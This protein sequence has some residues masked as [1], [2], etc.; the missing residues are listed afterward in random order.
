MPT[1]A[2]R[3]TQPLLGVRA[4]S[5]YLVAVTEVDVDEVL[6]RQDGASCTV[7]G[8]NEKAPLANPVPLGVEPG[9]GGL[10]TRGE[11]L[12]YFEAGRGYDAQITVGDVVVVV[13]LPDVS[14]D[15][16]DAGGDTSALEAT[17][18]ALGVDV[19]AKAPIASPAFTGTVTLPGFRLEPAGAAPFGAGVVGTL[20][21][22]TVDYVFDIG[23]N[24]RRVDV[25]EPSFTFTIESDY[26][27]VPGTHALEAYFEY[28]SADEGT[29][30]RPIFFFINRATHALTAV[31]KADTLQFQSAAGS[32]F[33]VAQPGT[34]TKRGTPGSTMSSGSAP[35]PPGH[36]RSPCSR[37]P[38]TFWR[39]TPTP[40][41]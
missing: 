6:I 37:T 17:V 8:N 7:F 11:L 22:S 14:P 38:S 10:S 33:M 27:P 21:N 3:Y 28:R 35:L 18:E 34:F 20:F 26:E 19:G 1:K 4:G 41:T 15:V 16:D 13:P 23:Y 39:S 5:D 36:P 32:N 9:D 30:F 25:T 24:P 2:V 40:P 31:Y 29:T 12:V